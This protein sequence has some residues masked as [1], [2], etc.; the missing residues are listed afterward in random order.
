MF[1]RYSIRQLCSSIEKTT[2]TK[3]ELFCVYVID[4]SH[5]YFSHI[6]LLF[7]FKD[8]HGEIF[9][10][11]WLRFRH[12]SFSS[13]LSRI[14]TISKNVTVFT[15]TSSNV[16]ASESFTQELYNNSQV[17]ERNSSIISKELS[18]CICIEKFNIGD[19]VI[20]M[21]CAGNHI[22]HTRCIKD[23][24]DCNASCPTCRLPVPKYC[25]GNTPRTN[26][27]IILK[28]R[29]QLNQICKSRSNVFAVHQET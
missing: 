29:S 8:K 10:T 22:F 7:F 18:C 24:L 4:H 1:N 26:R 27:K 20:C 6:H 11:P 5:H 16:V 17:V 25:D 23:W 2:A 12:E 3:C 9:N 13:L 14:H 28:V 21:P 19:N 15:I